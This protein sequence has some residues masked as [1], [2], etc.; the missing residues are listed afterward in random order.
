MLWHEFTLTLY[1]FRLL[2]MNNYLAKSWSP[3]TSSPK[4]PTILIFA[5]ALDA[6]MAWFAPFPPRNIP[7]VFPTRVS[8]VLG[9]RGTVATRS[10]IKLPTTVT[11]PIYSFSN[12]FPKLPPGWKPWRSLRLN[13]LSSET[14][15]AKASPNA[16]WIFPDDLK[17]TSLFLCL[18]TNYSF[19]YDIM[20][21]YNS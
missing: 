17:M 13:P 1:K 9:R 6:A 16:I 15:D 11:C 18:L 8:P 19:F 14:D 4:L 5:P 10:Y 12:W 20:N 2:F 7:N 21:M 3:N